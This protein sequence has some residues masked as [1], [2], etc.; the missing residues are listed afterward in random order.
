MSRVRQIKLLCPRPSNHP[1]EAQRFRSR[2]RPRT[3]MFAWSPGCLVGHRAG[4]RKRSFSVFFT[5]KGARLRL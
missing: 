5:R 2:H 1:A 3:G 4:R